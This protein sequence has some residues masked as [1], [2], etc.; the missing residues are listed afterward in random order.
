MKPICCISIIL[1]TGCHKS[2]AYLVDGNKFTLND[3]MCDDNGLY[4]HEGTPT[5]YCYYDG[6]KC[7]KAHEIKAKWYIKQRNGKKYFDREVESRK[8]FM[9]SRIYRRHRQETKFRNTVCRIK[10]INSEKFK[11]YMLVIN[12]WDEGIEEPYQTLPKRCHGNAKTVTAK[13]TPFLRTTK[14]TMDSLKDELEKGH[15]PTTVYD[16]GIQMSGGPFKC[17]SQSTQPRNPK[18]VKLI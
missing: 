15:R 12:E 7:I 9:L 18:Q 13:A 5:N 6:S 10:E 1:F 4:K 8:I 2:G 3:V 11:R 17:S 14:K 16:M